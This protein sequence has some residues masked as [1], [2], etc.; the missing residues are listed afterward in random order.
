MGLPTSKGLVVPV[1]L[2][3]SFLCDDYHVRLSTNLCLYFDR[4]FVSTRDQ[5]AR[6]R[7]TEL[8]VARADLRYRGFSRMSRDEFGYERFA[9]GELM[10]EKGAAAVGH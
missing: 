2:T 7:Q 10:G 6:C 4:I 3:D 5:A 8:P 1:D 9:S